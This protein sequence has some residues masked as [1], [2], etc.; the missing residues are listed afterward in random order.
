MWFLISCLF[1]QELEGK[2]SEGE[3]SSDESDQEVWQE[4]RREARERRLLAKQADTH[5]H[6]P[7]RPV[8]PKPV[9]PVLPKPVQLV[10]LKAKKPFSK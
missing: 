3:T 9:Q 6:R 2:P 1:L 4:V 8:P 5:H 7:D 10:P